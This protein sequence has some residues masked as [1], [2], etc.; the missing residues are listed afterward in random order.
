MP[1]QSA[2]RCLPRRPRGFVY[3][4]G[5]RFG[6]VTLGVM[7]TK[8]GLA[9]FL[10][11][12]CAA[13]LESQP[14]PLAARDVLAHIQD[15]WRSGDAHAIT[16]HFGARKVSIALSGLE[17]VGGHFSRSQSYYILKAH[18]E[19]TRVQDFEFEHLREPAPDDEL[20]LALA[21]RLYRVRGDGRVIRDRVLVALSREA[22]RWVISEIR[23]LR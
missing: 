12:T 14:P 4:E 5:V 13:Q 17:P 6:G 22:G 2:P 18:F 23:A 16:R 11:T 10:V 21:R 15:S 9:A 7:W 20:A 3:T 8:I 19:A 1:A